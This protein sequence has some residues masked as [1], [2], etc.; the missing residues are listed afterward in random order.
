MPHSISSDLYAAFGR[1]GKRLRLRDAPAHSLVSGEVYPFTDFDETLKSTKGENTQTATVGLGDTTIATVP[2]GERWWVHSLLVV[3]D[4][5]GDRNINELHVKVGGVKVTVAYQASGS[6]LGTGVIT[7]IP[8]DQ[9]DS[10]SFSVIGGTT[11][12]AWNPSI[13]YRKEEY[14]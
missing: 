1:L 10:I 2:A 5:T 3:R 14:F 4:S 7:P 12:G 9:G 6:F 8:L 11:N 13:V